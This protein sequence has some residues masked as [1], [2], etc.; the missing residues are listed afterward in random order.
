MLSS[1]SYSALEAYR[2]CPRKFKYTYVDR[3]AVIKTVTAD[4]YLGTAV[5]RTLKKL[6]TLGADGIVMPEDAVL[7]EYQQE[8]EKLDRKALSV[9]SDYYT[10][11]DYIRI[12]REILS[13]H[14]R[15]YQP[16]NQ[17]TLLGAELYLDFTLEGT[18]FK[19]RSIIDRLWKRD[20]GTVEICDYKTG[21]ALTRPDDPRFL[22]QMGLYQL[23]VQANYSQFDSIELAQYFLRKDEVIRRHLKAADLDELKEQIRGDVIETIEA[24]RL[25]DFPA[26]EGTHCTWCNFQHICPAK[27]HGRLLEDE[28]SD[29][30]QRVSPEQ[31]KELAD[32]FLAV[33]ADNKRTGL[34]LEALK[35]K[36][37]ELAREHDIAKFEGDGGVVTVSIRKKEEFVTKTEDAR[38]FAELSALC[39][40]MGLEEYFVLDGR[41]LMNGAYRK[42]RLSRDQEEEL[43]KFVS[44]RERTRVLGKPHQAI[45]DD[46]EG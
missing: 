23:A 22:Y 4:T 15:R 25:D 42:K 18:P 31:L 13:G 24:T 35:A 26:L 7:S 20:D 29:G 16:F 6:Y 38:A 36:L 41:A 10:V 9:T 2:A 3:V 11:D 33:Q 40:Q 28:E 32:R 43:G 39:R 44:A 34:E 37:I 45:D 14:Y 17:G 27:I 21:Q 5:H 12:G 46:D 1:Y 30:L 19:F 8:W